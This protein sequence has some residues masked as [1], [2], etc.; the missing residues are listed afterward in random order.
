MILRPCG[1]P[2]CG[3]ATTDSRCPT[4]KWK[5]D[6]RT[7]KQKGYSGARWARLRAHTLRKHPV[8]VMC[9]DRVSVVADHVVPKKRGGKDELDNLQGLCLRCHATKTRRGD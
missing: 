8:C 3:I 2:G 9:R 7:T 1:Y 4:H 6:V 5:G